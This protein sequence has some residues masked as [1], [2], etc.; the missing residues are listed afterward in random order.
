[1]RLHDRL[2]VMSPVLTLDEIDRYSHEPV[3]AV[4]DLII[5]ESIQA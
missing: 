1:M 4:E 3:S 2:S 5:S